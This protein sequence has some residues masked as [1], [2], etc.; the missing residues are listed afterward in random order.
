[1]KREIFYLALAGLLV[2]S[3]CGVHPGGRS[4]GKSE[5]QISFRGDFSPLVAK[6]GTSVKFAKVASPG[7]YTLFLKVTAS[8]ISPDLI[9]VNPD[10][11]F[12]MRPDWVVLVPNGN[13]R[14]FELFMYYNG[15]PATDYFDITLWTTLDPVEARTLDL[16]GTPVTLAINIGAAAV[17]TQ[18][19]TTGAA[20]PDGLITID[21]GGAY[22]VPL[23]ECGYTLSVFLTDTEFPGI[24]FGP[25]FVLM[26]STAGDG[27]YLIGGIPADR[28]YRIRMERQ[29]MGWGGASSAVLFAPAQINA[30]NVT[31]S[32][33]QNFS[34]TPLNFLVADGD[35]QAAPISLKVQGGWAARDIFHSL[36]LSA[37]G[38]AAILPGPIVQPGATVL[39]KVTGTVGSDTVDNFT[40]S[41][42]CGTPPLV[43]NPKAW[44]YRAPKID[45]V[46][47]DP[48]WTQGW[49]GVYIYSVGGSFD[50]LARDGK[51][52]EISLDGTGMTTQGGDTTFG[53]YIYFDSPIKSSGMHTIT[54]R[55]A[56]SN[57]IFPG[58]QG[59]IDSLQVQY[60]DT[61]G[62]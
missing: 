24:E 52:A 22:P 27:H 16:N 9:F 45:S 28:T 42:N 4:D 11:D 6:E 26:D 15:E 47:P 25:A 1:M 17:T 59:F 31:L 57:P 5:V 18:A 51:W 48:I 53:N 34:A 13:D 33:W 50:A 60:S 3:G 30:V 10:Y 55:N 12:E 37:P 44:W 43:A 58:F 54:V 7:S 62:W 20:A 32:G 39:Y 23:P 38:A 49:T 21:Q 61:V 36:S 14:T 41:D 29:Q 46:S 56:R 2:C 40:I 8:D 35:T 19:G